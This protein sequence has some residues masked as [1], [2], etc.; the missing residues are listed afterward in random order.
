MHL[1]NWLH[2]LWSTKNLAL[3]RMQ[4]G[5]T[6]SSLGLPCRHQLSGKNT[7]YMRYEIW[8]TN[9]TKFQQF[10]PASLRNYLYHVGRA[11]AAPEEQW[12]NPLMFSCEIIGKENK[13]AEVVFCATVKRDPLGLP[14]LYIA[15]VIPRSLPTERADWTDTALQESVNRVFLDVKRKAALL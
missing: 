1:N 9:L 7:Q 10:S 4:I 6:E 15:T 13:Y 2:Q 5:P 14:F 11:Y 3:F 12:H 8:T